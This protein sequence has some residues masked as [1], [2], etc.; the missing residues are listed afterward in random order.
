MYRGIVQLDANGEAV[1]QLPSYFDAVN[2]E[3]S[4]QLTAIG[5][6]TQPY[7]L[8]EEANNQFKV[9][10]APNTK[11]SWTVYAK[12][13]DPTIQY[14]SAKGKNYDQEEVMKPAKMKGKYYTPA[15]YNMPESMGIFSNESVEKQL[16]KHKTIGNGS[17]INAKDIKAISSETSTKNSRSSAYKQESPQEERL[18]KVDK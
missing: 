6:A 8:E 5:T 10:G 14:Y 4:Y 3:P 7:V 12:R 9:A 18:T 17:A 2:I 1:V 15:A 11:V 16:E 13:N